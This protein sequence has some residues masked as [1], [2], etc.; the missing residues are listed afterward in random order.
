M[1]LVETLVKSSSVR[2]IIVTFYAVRFDL[3][4][5]PVGPFLF[6]W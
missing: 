5:W 6:A 2:V 1:T 4:K 3:M